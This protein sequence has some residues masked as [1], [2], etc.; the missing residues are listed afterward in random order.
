MTAKEVVRRLKADG[1]YELHG[2]K[3]GHKQFSHPSKPGKTTVSMHPGDIPKWTLKKIEEQSG[4]SMRW[5]GTPWRL[6]G[7][8][9]ERKMDMRSYYAVFVPE[10]DGKVSV[11]FPDVPGCATWGESMESAFAQAMDALEGHLEAL[12]DNGDPIPAPTVY[13]AVWDAVRRDFEKEGESMPGGTI[14]QLVPVPDVREKP[15]RINVSLRKSTLGM[16]DRKAELAG[17]TRSGFLSKAAEAYHAG[18]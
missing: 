16:I 8:Q 14:L 7:R 11:W 17:M 18:E 6:R 13:G 1:W 2:K 10:A 9:G 5:G 12:A 15:M 4:V 3:T